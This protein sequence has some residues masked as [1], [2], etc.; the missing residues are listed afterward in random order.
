MPGAFAVAVN[1]AGGVIG[2]LIA[3]Q[4]LAIAAAAMGEPEKETDLLREVIG[5]SLYLL[6]FV[7]FVCFVGG[8]LLL[9]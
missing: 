4:S 2:K 8:M 1:T 7:V 9:G 3:P 5:W 6:L